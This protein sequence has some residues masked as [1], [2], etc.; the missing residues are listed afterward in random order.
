MLDGKWVW[1]LF[2]LSYSI[3]C[4]HSSAMQIY[5]R[6][7]FNSHRIGLVHKYGCRDVMWKRSAVESLLEKALQFLIELQ[8]IAVLNV[9]R[10]WQD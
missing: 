7:E 1:Y 5:I 4:I 9:V 8:N 6:K 3:D 2:V 10:N